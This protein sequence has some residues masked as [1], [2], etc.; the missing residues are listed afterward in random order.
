MPRKERRDRYPDQ[1]EE[2]DQLVRRA[3]LPRRRHR[4]GR[5][6]QHR[7]GDERGAREDQRRREPVEHLVEH[8]AVERERPPEVAL[9]HVAEPDQVLLRQRP[10]EPELP[11]ERRHV[12]RRRIGP[13][14]RERRVARDHRHDQE[15]DQRDPQQHRDR[16]DE[17][18]EDVEPHRLVSHRPSGPRAGGRARA[19]RRPRGVDP[20]DGRLPRARPRQF[21]STSFR[22]R[23]N[24]GCRSNPA[25]R[26]EVTAF[27]FQFATNTHGASSCTISCTCR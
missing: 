11:V 2:R 24:D 7:A 8:R 5:H 9:Q 22:S 27:C 25:T 18:P 15:H 21:F 6:P 26:S 13:E 14:D 20:P 16:R 10:V 3:V 1:H 19:R 17:P 4:A 23:K 12:L